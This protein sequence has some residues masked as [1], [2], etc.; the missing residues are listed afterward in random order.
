MK[1]FSPQTSGRTKRIFAA[2]LLFSIAA[3]GFYCYIWV[4][5]I[6]KNQNIR[7]FLGEVEALNT[8]KEVFSSIKEKIAET[9][10][11]REKLD[12]YFIPKDGVVS[13]LNRIQ[14]LGA[15]NRLEFKVDSVAIED[16][17]GPPENF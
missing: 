1:F 8:E 15:E 6:Q 17:A 13:F 7:V 10:P 2:A 5:I 14:A 9:A 16:E 4:K 12:S 3:V 11:L